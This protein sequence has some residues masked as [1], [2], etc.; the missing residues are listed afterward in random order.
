MNEFLLY[1]SVFI[2]AVVSAYTLLIIALD[3]SVDDR[4]FYGVAAV[5]SSILVMLV[6]GIV[7]LV[8]SDFDRAGYF[9][10]YVILTL[11]MLPLFLLWGIAE[12]SR[13]GSGVLLGGLFV[14]GVMILRIHQLW[15][16]VG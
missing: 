12:K 4:L 1:I 10:S 5:E 8:G 7:D 11:V 16:A 15:P 14:T 9:L 2:L 3:R 6:W 13:W